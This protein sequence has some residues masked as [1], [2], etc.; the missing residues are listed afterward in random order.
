MNPY[1]LSQV[2]WLVG[3]PTLQRQKAEKSLVARI[4]R[5][6]FFTCNPGVTQS[7]FLRSPLKKENPPSH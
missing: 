7:D 3:A 2:V 6:F 4:S 1:S 5:K